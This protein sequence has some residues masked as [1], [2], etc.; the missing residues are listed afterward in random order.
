MGFLPS[1]LRPGRA[2]VRV[3][4]DSVDRLSRLYTP[5]AL[6]VLALLG[7]ALQH[8]LAQPATCWTPAAFT[9]SQRDYTDRFCWAK[10]TFSLFLPDE[11]HDPVKNARHAYYKW[12]PGLLV[13]QALLAFV[14]CLPWGLFNCCAGQCLISVS[15]GISILLIP[16]PH[17]HHVSIASG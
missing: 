5:L 15:R 9:A 2:F 16:P 14:P 8:P 4:D 17:L 12:V 6:L 3:D 7:L 10:D 1:S 11:F 13:F